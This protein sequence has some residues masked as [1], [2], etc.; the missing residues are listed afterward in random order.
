MRDGDNYPLG[1]EHDPRAPYNQKEN[2]DKEI[3]VDITLTLRKTAK[4]L[5]SDYD[6]TDCGKDEDGEYFEEIDYSN[7]DLVKEVKEQ[8]ELPKGWEIEE[9]D[10]E[11]IK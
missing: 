9:I 10:V 11:Q 4:I 2:E 5:T 7:C 6:I 1:A 3:E 8:V